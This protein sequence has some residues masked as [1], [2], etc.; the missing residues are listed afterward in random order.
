VS[1]L[2]PCCL[3]AK[4]GHCITSCPQFKHSLVEMTNLQPKQKPFSEDRTS[5][6]VFPQ[7]PQQKSAEIPSTATQPQQNPWHTVNHART[8]PTHPPAPRTNSTPP[9]AAT[10]SQPAPL[11]QMD[12]IQSV[13]VTF[14]THFNELFQWMK[15]MDKRVEDLA[16]RDIPS[17]DK[18]EAELQAEEQDEYDD[19][20]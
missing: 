13:L 7:L 18:Q 11:N 20:Q 15:K 10:S 16:S 3:C 8:K 5:T 6:Q 9:A 1:P 4:S 17:E 2:P 12:Q 19:P 14:Q